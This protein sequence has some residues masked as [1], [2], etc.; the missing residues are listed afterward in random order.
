MKPKYAA[1]GLALAAT[2]FASSSARA[3]G[4][5]AATAQALFD[6][7]RALM[8]QGK[9]AEACPKLAASQRLD[10]GAGT[11]MNLAACYDKNGQTASAW[12]TYLEAAP[13]A[14]SS[15][16][17]DWEAH[18]KERAAAIEP[19]LSRLTIVVPPASDVPGLHIER[20]GK[21]VLHAEWG[22]ALPIDPGAHPILVTAPSKQQWSTTVSVGPNAA[23]VSVTVPPLGVEQT[24][25]DSTPVPP[26]RGVVTPL[27]VVP[28]PPPENDGS[29]QR[30]IGLGVGGVGIVGLAVGIVLGVHAKSTYDSAF[31]SCTS[32]NR[33]P[34]SGVSGVDDA[35]SQATVSTVVT[36]IGA[37]ALVGG[38]ILYFTAPSGAPSSTVGLR[39]APTT[40]GA[41]F[42]IGGAW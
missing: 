20:D 26:S 10:P 9:L 33:G 14:R 38:G 5:D 37:A 39:V 17:A 2:A 30:A 21:E 36:V 15:G 11:L 40:G 19:T 1:L 12:V 24:T 6:E 34:A 35:R 13:A 22:S 32:D 25:N 31:A 27:P 41:A 42:L 8:G 7:G 18:A 23:S 3:Q 29:T 28:P 4:A 16:H